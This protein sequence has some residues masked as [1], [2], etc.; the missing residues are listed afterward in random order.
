M[1]AGPPQMER[2]AHEPEPDAEGEPIVLR[3]GFIVAGGVMAALAA[4]LPAALRL[5]ED[6]SF[7]RAIEQWVVLSAVATPVAVAA[8]AVLRRARAGLHLLMG[9]RAPVL[10]IGVLWWCVLELALLSAFGAVLR[11][12]THNHA[13]AGVTFA[14]FAVVTGILVGLFA[15][16]TALILAR[17]GASLQRVALAIVGACTFL[18][19]MFVG[20]RMARADGL[21]TAAG[22]VDSIAFAVTTTIASSRLIGR[23][24]PLA[25]SGV[26]VAVLVIM[27]GLTTLRFSP[28]LRAPLAHTAPMHSL[29]IGVFE[30]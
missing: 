19:I 5:G 20:I 25:I 12:T 11:L 6:G 4:S 26:P 16:R 22:L 29:V 17:G 30:P 27:V 21:H 2:L 14:A 28:T 23:W 9:E 8:V 15:R 3:V 10:A 7:G 1:N 24:R 13:L 18:G